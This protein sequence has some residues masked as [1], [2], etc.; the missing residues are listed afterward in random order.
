MRITGYAFISLC[1][2]L[3]M[4]LQILPGAGPAQAQGIDETLYSEILV[5]QGVEMGSGARPAAL[6][7]AYRALSDDL[8]GL[9]WNPAGLA[10][11]RR[12]ELGL[13]LSQ[14]YTRD[15]AMIPQ[16]DLNSTQLSRTRLNELGLVFPV[17]TYRGSLVFALGYHMAHPFDA[18]GTFSS[19]DG[20]A[21]FM[22]DELESGRLGLWSLGGGIDLSPA[23]SVGLAARL[24]TGFDDYSYVE[25]TDFPN[26]DFSAFDQSINAD[27]SGFN[28]LAGV[29][30]KALPWLR[31]GATLE[32]PLKLGI[33][34]SYSESFEERVGG[35]FF[36]EETFSETYEYHI[37]RPFRLGIGAAALV[38]RIGF[39]AD[40][41][42]NDWSQISYADE[43]PL[44]GFDK[45]QANRE[46]TRQLRPTVDLHGGLEYWLPW[47]DARLQAGYAYLPSPFDDSEVLSAKHVFSGGLGVLVDPALQ[48][49][50][51]LTWATWERLLAGWEEDLRQASFVLTLS[52]RM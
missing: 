32:T 3:L 28:F 34:E 29:M 8:S 40:A 48:I 33:E 17:P 10:S 52:Y 36:P 16:G 15:E 51:S 42:L 20:N 49:Q 7:G 1:A 23:V 39:S 25:R 43:P 19:E 12:I 45:E 50:G 30:L 24:W 27:L 35:E 31:V 47:V 46:I 26:G 22:A 5:L 44:V 18:F 4:G 21:A 13:G 37:S 11:V 6:G 14:Y 9:Y 38:N 41:V 2:A